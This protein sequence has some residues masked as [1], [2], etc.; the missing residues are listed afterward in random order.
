M[1]NIISEI[2][3]V[4]NQDRQITSVGKGDVVEIKDNTKEYEDHID[5]IYDVYGSAGNL[6]KSIIN[7]PVEIK[8]AV[9]EEHR[10]RLFNPLEA[11]YTSHRTLK[12]AQDSKLEHC[13]KVLIIHENINGA[14]V[15]V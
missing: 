8:Y 3:I 15:V 14:W 9:N 6:L 13:D 11:T 4:T 12:D 5:F 7:C 10:F 2:A 1:K